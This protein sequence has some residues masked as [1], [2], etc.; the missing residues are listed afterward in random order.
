[1]HPISR[2][3]VVFHRSCRNPGFKHISVIVYNIF[4]YF[5]LSLSADKVYMFVSCT[6]NLLE[7]TYDF[8]KRT[9][10]LQKWILNFQDLLRSQSL[11]TVPVCIVWKYFPHDKIV[12][13]HKYDEYM[14]SIDSGVC[15]KLWSIFLRIVRAYLLTTEYQVVQ[16]LP[17]ISI[18]EQFDSIHVKILQQISFLLL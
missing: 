14:K 10:F 2:K 13:I 18:S 4:A 1:M 15:H 6:S 12:C 16:F 7:Q 11:E 17:S 8:Q 5:T 9:M 3:L